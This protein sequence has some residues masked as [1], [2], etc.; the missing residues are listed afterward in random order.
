MYYFVDLS[1]LI[2]LRNYFGD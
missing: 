1:V 2:R